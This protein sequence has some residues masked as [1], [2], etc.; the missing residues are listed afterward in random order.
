MNKNLSTDIEL[1][2]IAPTQIIS[3]EICGI[4]LIWE[5]RYDNAE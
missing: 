5:S 1:S 4:F 2:E 3:P